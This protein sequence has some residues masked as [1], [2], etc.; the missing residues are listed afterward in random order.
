MYKVVKY[1]TDLQ[2]D[3]YAYKV[4]DIFP[5]DGMKVTDT[6]IAKLAGK[7][8]LRGV[9]L[10]E[11]IEDTAKGLNPAVPAQSEKIEQESPL[12]SEANKT[13]EVDEV[14]EV[15]KTRRG[16]KAKED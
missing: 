4:G 10:I 14:K 8:N 3:G 1:F 16:R 13:E 9:P 12:I 2:D 5:R 6:R 15:K 7:D 11:E